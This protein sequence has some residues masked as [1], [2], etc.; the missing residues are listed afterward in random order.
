[1]HLRIDLCRSAFLPKLGE[2]LA[3]ETSDHAWAE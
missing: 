3:F 2:S 1:V